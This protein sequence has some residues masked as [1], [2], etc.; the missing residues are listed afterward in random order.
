MSSMSR[1]ASS[2]RPLRANRVI[3][4]VRRS[5]P[6]LRDSRAVP[7][8]CTRGS[9]AS[10]HDAGIQDRD[11]APALLGAVRRAFPWLRHVF[12]DTAYAGGKLATALGRLGSWTIEI[13]KR[14]ADAQGFT[15]LPRRW[16][17]ERTLAWLNRNRRL[18][19]DFEASLASAAV[20]LLIASVKLLSRRIARA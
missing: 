13:V 3:S 1:A 14:A 16:V 11:G 18:A 6:P 10:V 8:F 12:A 17:V 20:W 19:K 2:V 15:L 9:A 7:G 4:A 5:A